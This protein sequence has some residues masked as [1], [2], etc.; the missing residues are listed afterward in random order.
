MQIPQFKQSILLHCKDLDIN[1][2]ENNTVAVGYIKSGGE[3]LK[4]GFQWLGDKIAAGVAAG[5]QYL[6]SK[7]E[8]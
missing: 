5:G 6:N 1:P 8:K 7:V 4:E 2:L 3:A